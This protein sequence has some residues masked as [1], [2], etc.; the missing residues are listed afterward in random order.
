MTF[1]DYIRTALKNFSRQKLRTFLTISA[2]TVGSLSLILMFSLLIGMRQSL[3]DTFQ[4]M[5]AFELVTVTRDPNSTDN[6]QL[7]TTSNGPAS[8]EG[9]KMDETTLQAVRKIANVE[10]AT[11]VLSV[12]V[13]TIRLEGQEKKMWSNLLAYEPETNVFKLPVLAG[14]NLNSG[15]MDKIV[16]GSEFVQTYGYTGNPQGLIGKK[17]ILAY[18]AGGGNGPDWGPPPPKPNWNGKDQKEFDKNRT[19]NIEAE[20]VGVANNGNM[21]SNQNYIN[22]VWGRKLMT[23]VYW[24]EDSEGEKTCQENFNRERQAQEQSGQ[25]FIGNP[26]SCESQRE[27]QLFREDKFA[28][29]G[30]GSIIARV[31]NKENVKAVGER[32]EKMG[33]GATTAENMITQMNKIFAAVSAGLGVVGGISLFVAALGIINTMVMATYERIREIGVLRACGATRKTIRRLFTYEAA[34]LGFCGGIVGVVISILLGQVAKFLVKKFGSILG[35]LPVD[36]IGDFPW[37]LVCSLVG[38]TTLIGLVAGLYPAVRASRLNPV[39]ALR[40]E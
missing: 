33:Y 7:I 4:N 25:K 27:M 40:S 1:V 20:I 9:K 31:N 19:I 8:D 13:K 30:Y 24:K 5:G 37:W 2:I 11:P 21:E 12:W 3:L 34:F 32:I 39:E 16:V 17:A 23:D 38:F 26:P 29:E 28:K 6:P 22:I 18:E 35:N 10:S 14:R 15:D 36:H